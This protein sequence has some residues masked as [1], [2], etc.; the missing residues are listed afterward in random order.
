MR[1]FPK[2]VRISTKFCSHE[3]GTDLFGIFLGRFRYWITFLRGPVFGPDLNRSAPI[4]C[5]RNPSP[6]RFLERYTADRNSSDP[7]WTGPKGLFFYSN[8]DFDFKIKIWYIGLICVHI[9]M[10]NQKMVYLLFYW[11]FD[12]HLHST[13]RFHA[14]TTATKEQKW[15][16]GKKSLNI[17]MPLLMVE[18]AMDDEFVEASFRLMMILIL[19]CKPKTRRNKILKQD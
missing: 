4:P 13:G 11:K 10:V 9:K 1:E 3:N 18:L 7:V 12:W 17:F 14:K 15:P 6:Y 2:T 19:F 16:T 5:E 8:H